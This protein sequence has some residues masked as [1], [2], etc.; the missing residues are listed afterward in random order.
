MTSSAALPPSLCSPAVVTIDAWSEE[1]LL[2]R[3][4]PREDGAH[5]YTGVPAP[6]ALVSVAAW[7]LIGL[8]LLVAFPLQAVLFAVC[9]PFDP[10]RRVSGRFFRRMA[11]LGAGLNPYW[12]FAIA[13]APAR[14]MRPTVVVANHAS[15][16]D[17]FLISRVPFEMKWLGKASLFRVPLLGWSMAL[18]G[19][20]AVRRGAHGSGHAA[21]AV[22]ARWVRRG[23]PVIIFPE[24]TRSPDGALGPFKDGAFK[25]A[26]ET[27]AD[28]LPLG[29]A[30]THEAL[31]KRSGRVG[32]SRGRLV[33]GAPIPSAGKTVAQLKAEVRA[34]VE[35]L[36]AEAALAP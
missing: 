8:A 18:A 14:P 33:G 2:E 26:V 12:D 4:S 30:G 19:D 29:I 5:A 22:C 6:G 15:N 1:P 7:L 9:W 34:A 16:V 27:G 3:S 31:P 28:V 32:R 23:V 10:L 24:G 21:L 13:R 35:R 36:A 11:S 20:V 25:L 17:P